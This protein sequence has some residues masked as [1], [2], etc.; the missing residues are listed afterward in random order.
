MKG[1]ENQA[2][3]IESG[4]RTNYSEN[5]NDMGNIN[6]YNE[7]LNSISALYFE[8][9]E[10]LHPK[11]KVTIVVKNIKKK[12]NNFPFAWDLC[13]ILQEKFILLPENFWLQDDISI[14]PF[15]YGNTWVSNTFH[16]YCLQFQLP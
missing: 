10:L 1:A 4:L 2:K 16:Q 5:L 7:F 13:R 14:A 12:G 9:A 15:G 11:A 3:R 6:D 8:I